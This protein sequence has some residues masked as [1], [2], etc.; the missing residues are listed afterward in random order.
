MTTGLEDGGKEFVR[1]RIDYWRRVAECDGFDMEGVIIPRGIAGLSYVN[2]K[3]R[4]FRL[5][6]SLPKIYAMAG[7]H[8]YNMLK[9]TNFQHF[10]LLQFSKSGDFVRSYFITS[11]AIDPCSQLQKTFQVRLDEKTYGNL[12]LT[13]SIAR[14]TDEEKVTMKKPFIAHFHVEAVAD[15]FYKGALPDWPSADELNNRKRFYLVT[16]SDLLANDWIRLYLELTLC[17]RHKGTSERD[18]SKLQILTV[19]IE[20]KEDVQPP[21]A[22]LKA[23]SAIVYITFKGLAEAEIGDEIGEHVERKAIVRRVLDEC[24]GYLTLRGG[25]SNGEKPLHTAEQ[26]VTLP[27]GEDQNLENE[28]KRPRLD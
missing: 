1:R 25:F 13:I 4:H 14:P 26:T 8:R 21:N 12:D 9:G 22:R 2:C 17:V 19:A 20:T 23:K 3:H 18:L 15:A 28:C 11:V 27:S 7:L 5:R 16:E 24:S 10:D 6:N